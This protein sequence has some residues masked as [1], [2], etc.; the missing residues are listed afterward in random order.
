MT[1]KV[2]DDLATLLFARANPHAEHHAAQAMAA[3]VERV[4]RMACALAQA[5][6]HI[7]I[8]GLANWVGRLTAQILDL[9][10][11]EGRRMRPR[12]IGLLRELDRLE[13]QMQARI[14]P[15]PGQN[16]ADS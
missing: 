12:L 7:E 4:L 2:Q 8:D 15:Q 9:E 13:H 14:P 16:R 11:A 1:H 6:R 10:P 5:G 3:S